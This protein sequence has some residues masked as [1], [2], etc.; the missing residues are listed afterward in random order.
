MK[1]N[2][3][4]GKKVLKIDALLQ[5][6]ED[7]FYKDPAAAR[8][9]ARK[10]ALLAEDEQDHG[11]LAWALYIGGRA[12]TLFENRTA[13]REMLERA[14]GLMKNSG[15]VSG[16]VLVLDA[17]GACLFF[18][19]ET[20]AA[21]D[22][23]LYALS[24]A[25][26]FGDE[27]V[28]MRIY[29][30]MGLI[31]KQIKNPEWAL[32]Y[33]YKALFLAEKREEGAYRGL[34]L[35]YLG[36]VYAELHDWDMAEEKLNDARALAEDSGARY[37]EAGLHLLKGGLEKARKSYASAARWFALGRELSDELGIPRLAG[38]AC[39][40]EGILY[41]QRRR[42][43]KAYTLLRRACRIAEEQGL[44][45][46]LCR[47]YRYR[48]ELAQRLQRY[49][50]ALFYFRR[51]HR[52]LAQ[53]DLEKVRKRLE[54][55]VI[56]Y[57]S[58]HAKNEAESFR[59]RN[60]ELE[61]SYKEIKIISEIGRDITSS[62]Y[63][64]EILEKAYENVRYLLEPIGFGIASY[65]RSDGELDYQY[66]VER[67]KRQPEFSIT[68]ESS[69]HSSAYSFRENQALM[70]NSPDE[71]RSLGILMPER[72]GFTVR[73]LM[74]VPLRV[75]EELVGL[76]S[77]LSSEEQAYREH[78]LNI[79]Q[80]VASYVAIAL[81]NA[82]NHEALTELNRLVLSEKEDL[83]QAYHRINYLATHDPLTE[84]PNRHL[85][86]E[87]LQ[88]SLTMAEREQHRVG[89]LYLDLDRFKPINDTLGHDAGDRVLKSVADRMRSVLRSSDTVAR[90]G[91]D[92][93]VVVLNMV[94]DSA[95]PEK[96][97]RKLIDAVSQTVSMGGK[98]F[99]L[100]VSIGISLYPED[101]AT[102]KGLMGKADKAMYSV[103]QG[104]KNGYAF[105]AALP[106]EAS[107]GD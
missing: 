37:L 9:A 84:L 105:F 106:A 96:A 86:M 3:G 58:E 90:V 82:Q 74:H 8:E 99:D 24:S 10:A 35:L 29:C 20:E 64:D 77:V 93:F 46:L 11:A 65:N 32:R 107:G 40:E 78:H 59:H 4:D 98:E 75:G 68:L 48:A 51:Y 62:L 41:L 39:L 95:G 45:D 83:E 97:A 33:L 56:L 69:E 7:L 104:G 53:R 38:T 49:R 16:E 100:G 21:L 18:S 52:M 25:E 12:E 13:A 2:G 85:L 101:D 60:V 57:E 22:H 76:I 15:D 94:T 103:K 73:S 19:G 6:A 79:L 66:Y 70:L 30:S 43:R 102:I 5:D 34:I 27:K 31:Y 54:E 89:L 91:G 67:E 28:L 80:A 23:L 14:L 44:P 92:E 61:R 71:A 87:L 1:A 17:L 26:H 42:W 63:P 88:R 36:E 50:R 55:L 47:C 72:K 81:K